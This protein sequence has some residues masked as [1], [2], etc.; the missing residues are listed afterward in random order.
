[1]WGKERGLLFLLSYCRVTLKAA[2]LGGEGRGE[3]KKLGEPE[4]IIRSS[5]EKEIK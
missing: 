4:I 2:N 5:S 1:M 3:R